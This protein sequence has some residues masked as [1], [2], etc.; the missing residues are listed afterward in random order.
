MSQKVLSFGLCVCV[1]VCHYNI[2]INRPSPSLH[3]SNHERFACEDDVLMN[4]LVE[5]ELDGQAAAKQV[6]ALRD[7]IRRLREVG[8]NILIS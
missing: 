2:T 7:V 1:C 4:K 6:S 8:H 3:S 5:V